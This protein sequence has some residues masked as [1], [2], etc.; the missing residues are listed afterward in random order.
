MKS[1]KV[2][3]GIIGCGRIAREVFINSVVNSDTGSLYA[4]AS[5]N[6]EKAKSLKNEFGFKKSY[7]D[8][9]SLLEDELVDAVYIGLPN[10]EHYKWALEAAKRYKHILCEKP[11][12]M[13]LDE[14]NQIAIKA[15]ENNV[16]FV[17]NYAFRFHPQSKKIMDLIENRIVGEIKSIIISIHFNIQ[18]LLSISKDKK[19]IR[20]AQEM[21]GG[22]TRDVVCY[23]NAFSRMIYQEEPKSVFIFAEPDPTYNVDL[24]SSGILNFGNGK[25]S[26]FSTGFQSPC[27]QQARILCSDGEIIVEAPFHPRKKEDVLIIRKAKHLGVGAKCSYSSEI[28]STPIVEPFITII[29]Y[30]GRAINDGPEVDLLDANESLHNMRLLDACIESSKNR[31]E[32]FLNKA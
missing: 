32:V 11:A 2:N 26:V 17:E 3:W 18:Y 23:T 4:V 25:T 24:Q 20:L 28:V 1:K 21:G 30:F 27:G 7:G 22:A 19:N 8:Y 13:N 5:R 16:F 10:S 29:D 12:T 14:C 6:E 15:K 9:L 31:C